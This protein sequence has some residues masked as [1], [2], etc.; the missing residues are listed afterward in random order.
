MRFFHAIFSC[1]FFMRFFQFNS[2]K[3]IKIKIHGV[4]TVN[5]KS[6]ATNTAVFSKELFYYATNAPDGSLR[7]LRVE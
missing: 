6:L 5:K 2:L 7:N 3:F 4:K 1:D